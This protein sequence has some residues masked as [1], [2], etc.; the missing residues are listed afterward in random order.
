MLWKDR[1]LSAVLAAAVAAAALAAVVRFAPERAAHT[2]SQLEQGITFEATGIPSNEII[3]SVDGNGAEAEL[4]TYWV[5]TYADYI[6]NMFGMDLAESWDMQLDEDTTVEQLVREEAMNAVKQQLVLENLAARY[7]IG[8]SAEDAAALE[9]RRA[10]NIETLGGEEEYRARIYEL[11]VSETGFNRLLRT[12]LLFEG[13]YKSYSTPG[14]PLYADD[15]VLHAYAA[16]AGWITADHILIPTIDLTTRESL[17]AETVAQ[18]RALAEEL[19]WRLRESSDP[20]ALFGELADEY[21]QDTGRLAYPD[22]YTF[23][24]GSM[25]DEF[26]AAARALKENEYSDIV[27]SPYGYHII[28]RRPLNVAEAVEAV[29]SEY[30]DVFFRGEYE[31]AELTE[32]PAA[33]RYDIPAVWAA[34]RA[35]QAQ[36]EEPAENGTAE[37]E[38]T[39]SVK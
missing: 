6:E 31:R 34:L 12:D 38:T 14:S 1:I 16:G 5:G 25:V 27:E 3:A 24:Y 15:D 29:R 8:L 23:T 35:A 39:E 13:L 30:F 36:P 10:Q 22:G 32:T 37:S 11:G 17:D 26:D 20:V 4:L 9:Q 2:P 33:A 19:L 7:G 18:N 28:L 21:S